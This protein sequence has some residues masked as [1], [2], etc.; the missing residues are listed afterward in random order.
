M[1][2]VLMLFA[3]VLLLPAVPAQAQ[4]T[5]TDVPQTFWLEAGGFRVSAETTLRLGGA[6]GPGSDIVFE[7]DLQVP[8]STTQ[9]YLGGFW[10]LG[11]RHQVSLNWTRVKREGERVT[12]DEEIRWGDEV[13]RV[14]AQVQGTNDSDFLSGVYRFAL[15]KNDKFEVGPALGL[16]YVWV[17]A[18]LRGQAGVGIGGDELVQ[19]I[20]VQSTVGSITGDLGGY[21]YWWPGERWLVRSDARYI[22]ASFE[23]S[24][25]SVTEARVSLT[26]YAWRQ[27]GFG[28]QYTYTRFRYDRGL[29]V[30]S[31]SGEYK[32]DGL[33]FLVNFAF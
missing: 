12:A 6:V 19:D 5:E 24:E 23:E 29:L 7:R 18:G 17:S 11:R 31:L 25:A 8:G 15:V 2:Q 1:R 26:W 27:V 30:T 21:L 13:F 28:A 10:R 3:L 4:W 33:Q 9:G 14:G 32:Y 16:G 20:E 22:F